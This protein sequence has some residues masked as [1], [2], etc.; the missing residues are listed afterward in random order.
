MKHI[1]GSAVRMNT[2]VS[3]VAGTTVVLD[4]LTAPDGT[5]ILTSQAMSFDTVSTSVA[6][7]VW[8]S[9][10]TS[11]LGR[12]QYKTKATNGAYSDIDSGYFYLKDG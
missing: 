11:A 2:E 10:I 1:R 3:I 6:F 9:L 8:Q 12:Y 4:S 7:V 5:E